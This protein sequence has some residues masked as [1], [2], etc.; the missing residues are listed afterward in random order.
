MTIEWTGQQTTD[1]DTFST[2]LQA[3][4]DGT[5]VSVYFSQEAVQ[6]Y[7]VEACKQVAEQKL[8]A[9]GTIPKKVTIT[10]ADFG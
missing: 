7:G 3:K 2:V 6:D 10:T 4:V 1:P 8:T 9:A 5:S